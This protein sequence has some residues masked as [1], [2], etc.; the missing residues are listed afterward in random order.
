MNYRKW[1]AKKNHMSPG[2]F[3]HTKQFCHIFT[4]LDQLFFAVFCI[5]ND[6]LRTMSTL[7]RTTLWHLCVCGLIAR[8]P[9]STLYGIL[10][11]GHDW[12]VCLPVWDWV[13]RH[14][15]PEAPLHRWPNSQRLSSYMGQRFE[16]SLII[17]NQT[18]NLLL[19]GLCACHL[20]QRTSHKTIDACRH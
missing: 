16:K 8:G 3:C 9:V 15:C 20:V 6:L 14:N 13:W 12:C 5:K 18:R 19:G 10:K 17:E 1:L 2:L 7:R 11:H 4:P